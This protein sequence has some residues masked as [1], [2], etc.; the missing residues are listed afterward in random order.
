MDS[1]FL[2]L[3]DQLLAKRAAAYPLKYYNQREELIAAQQRLIS[4]LTTLAQ[5]DSSLQSLAEFEAQHGPFALDQVIFVVGFPKSGTTFANYL[6]DGHPDLLVIP[7]DAL[8]LTK[9]QQYEG[10]TPAQRLEDMRRYLVTLALHPIGLPPFW[11]LSGGQPAWQL[12][13]QLLR[14]FEDAIGKLGDSPLAVWQAMLRALRMANPSARRWVEKTPSNEW[15]VGQ[16]LAH[17]PAAK[18]VHLVRH[19][20]SNLVSMKKMPMQGFEWDVMGYQAAY[21][22]RSYHLAQA[23]LKRYGTE[24]YRVV[25]YED[26]TE[27]TETTMRDLADFLGL[28]YHPTLAH[29]TVLGLPATANSSFKERR[30]VNQDVLHQH[31]RWRK[32][33]EG[34]EL[35]LIAF[36]VRNQLATYG[37]DLGTSPSVLD[38]WRA[39]RAS[40]AQ[41]KP[42]KFYRAL[43]YFLESY[44]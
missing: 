22:R 23:N 11:M 7:G 28:D 20:Y 31:E 18:V 24:R 40:N 26:L 1:E 38:Y 43:R 35:H 3:Y 30:E 10:M 8:Y 32:D 39:V 16:L 14:Y 37:Y 25:R 42:L 4:E 5:N 27:Q 2:A 33:L 29:A 15:H 21:L 17:Y 6:L 41:G 34:W 44:R 13:A 19:P 9:L 12:Y 36:L